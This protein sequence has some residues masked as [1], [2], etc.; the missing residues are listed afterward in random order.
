LS[1]SIDWTDLQGLDL[2]KDLLGTSYKFIILIHLTPGGD[3]KSYFSKG[4][5]S[6]RM[7]INSS[8]QTIHHII[9]EILKHQSSAAKSAQVDTLQ[10]LQQ[11]S[12]E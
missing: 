2:E 8:C 9:V 1:I 12:N 10:A 4:C 11:S 6:N 5:K 3:L 7:R